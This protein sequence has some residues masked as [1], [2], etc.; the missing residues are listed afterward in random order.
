[1]T[2][3]TTFFKAPRGWPVGVDWLAVAPAQG[4]LQNFKHA[5]HAKHSD[6]EQPVNNK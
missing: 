1:M 2:T 4:G 3:S 5:K 6:S